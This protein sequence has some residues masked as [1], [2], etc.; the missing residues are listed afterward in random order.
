[1]VSKTRLEH[2]PNPPAARLGTPNGPFPCPQ[3]VFRLV[4]SGSLLSR[5]KQL[6]CR[7]LKTFSL[8]TPD[9]FPAPPR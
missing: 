2:L 5:E 7:P 3:G 4:T 1:M 6:E 8:Q 9:L